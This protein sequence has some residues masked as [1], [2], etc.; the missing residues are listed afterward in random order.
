MIEKTRSKSPHAVR[1]A[2][3]GVAPA[4]PG[5]SAGRRS[6]PLILPPATVDQALADEAARIKRSVAIARGEVVDDPPAEVEPALVDRPRTPA[7]A[8]VSQRT[9]AETRAEPSA[10]TGAL[11]VDRTVDDVAATVIA[12]MRAVGEAHERHL[13]AIELEA[14]RRCELL[15]A[16]AELDAELIRLNARREAHS[17]VSAARLR[18]GEH[19]SSVQTGQLDEIGETFSRFAESI[20][21]TI[22]PG[23]SGLY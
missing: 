14:A 19:L 22:A 10:E 5:T 17:V 2:L 15:T 16:Q 8:A 21:E 20:E 9:E 1:I 13:E 7:A 23:S 18:V 11:A 12:A 3:T 6:V 4:D